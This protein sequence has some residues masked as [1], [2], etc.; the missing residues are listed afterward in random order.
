MHSFF[1]SLNLYSLLG[2]IKFLENSKI[3]RELETDQNRQVFCAFTD[4]KHTLVLC[5]D[6]RRKRGSAVHTETRDNIR[7]KQ[8]HSLRGWH[9]F[10][11][12]AKGF[13][14]WK[15]LGYIMYALEQHR[16]NSHSDVSL[17]PSREMS[18]Y[19][20][21]VISR[22]GV[23]IRWCQYELKSQTEGRDCHLL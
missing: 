21:S 1:A 20:C 10:F 7:K 16:L 15:C 18:M 5:S 22:L 6:S 23:N 17:A 12:P 8:E 13:E 2:I 3:Q 9:L 11:K 19:F 14:F 4:A